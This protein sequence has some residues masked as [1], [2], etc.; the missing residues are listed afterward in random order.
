ML[1]LLPVQ[2]NFLLKFQVREHWFIKFIAFLRS[3]IFSY[4]TMFLSLNR[5]S[6]WLLSSS[7]P[8]L[9]TMIRWCIIQQEQLNIFLQGFILCWFVCTAVVVLEIWSYPPSWA[10]PECKTVSPFTCAGKWAEAPAPV[11]LPTS[12][13][14][15]VSS[16]VKWFKMQ[17]QKHIY[18]SLSANHK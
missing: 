2:E 17:N 8:S 12:S 14:L 13:S 11:F 3:N 1:R 9:H 4:W 15:V 5:A 18:N 6:G 16:F 7:T 10:P